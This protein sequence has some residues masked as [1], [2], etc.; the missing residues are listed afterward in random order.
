MLVMPSDLEQLAFQLDPERAPGIARDLAGLPGA[1]LGV[2]LGA[3]YPVLVPQRPA[4]IEAIA[5]LARDGL[6]SRRLRGDILGRLETAVTGQATGEPW[7]RALQ[8]TSRVTR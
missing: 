6:S 3:A 8:W 1:E 5:S 2:V 4:L 7:Q